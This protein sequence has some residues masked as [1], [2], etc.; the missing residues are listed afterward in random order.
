MLDGL[1]IMPLNCANQLDP[2]SALTQS[3]NIDLRGVFESNL[4]TSPPSGPA[5]SSKFLRDRGRRARQAECRD[6]YPAVVYLSDRDRVIECRNRIQWII[7]HRRSVC[8]N[9]W[10]GVKCFGTR[11][12]LLRYARTIDRAALARLHAL[13]EYFAPIGRDDDPCHGPGRVV[14]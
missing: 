9:S 12:V 4:G 14:L 10:R 11:D 8:A 7:Q 2:T 3:G 5:G 13:P 1:L 6:D